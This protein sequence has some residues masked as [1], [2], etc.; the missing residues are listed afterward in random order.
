MVA[1]GHI[2]SAANSDPAYLPGGVSMHPQVI[3]DSLG[4]K[5]AHLKPQ[6]NQFSRLSGLD[7]VSS[8]YVHT[9]KQTTEHQ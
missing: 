9:N 8:T 6:L 7:S 4:S 2:I 5:T 1:Q 3:H